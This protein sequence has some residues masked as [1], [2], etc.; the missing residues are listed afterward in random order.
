MGYVRYDSQAVLEAMNDLYCNEL[1]LL[2]NLFL[3]SV[4]LIR[5]ERVGSRLK[6]VY[7]PPQTPLERV[8]ASP[9]ANPTKV[10]ELKHWRDTINPFT[11]SKT[12]DVKLDRIYQMANPRHSPQSAAH[13][14]NAS[15]LPQ[16]GPSDQPVCVLA[17][18]ESTANRKHTG[19]AEKGKN[20]LQPL[21]NRTMQKHQNREKHRV[22][23]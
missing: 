6:R 20:T 22:T 17:S 23:L 8:M 5:K 16:G 1:R 21:E 13:A 14:M 3:P 9:T 12:I 7:G 10:A 15:S 18:A 19:R 2:Q 11:L 4:K